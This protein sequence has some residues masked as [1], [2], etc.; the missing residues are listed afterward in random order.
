MTHHFRIQ[1]NLNDGS[2]SSSH[3]LKNRSRKR[4][5]RFISQSKG[6]WNPFQG[7]TK[8]I[9]CWKPIEIDDTATMECP[10]CHSKAHQEHMLRWLSKRNYCPYCNAKW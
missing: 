2:N 10:H 6:K 3:N 7:P 4:R 9:I 8:C 1:T 5:V